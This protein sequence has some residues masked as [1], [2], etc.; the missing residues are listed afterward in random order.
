MLKRFLMLCGL[1]LCSLGLPVQAADN[2]HGQSFKDWLGQCE[3]APD[4]KE[5]CYILQRLQRN[6]TNNTLMIT[7][8]GY[9]LETNEALVV[10]HLPAVLDVNEMLLFKTDD[11]DAISINYRCDDQQCR[12]G[13]LLDKR[14]LGEFKRGRQALI[15]FTNADDGERVLLPV[16]LMGFTAGFKSLQ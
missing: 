14:M 3:V 8:I 5:F 4:G 9:H 1:G 7:Q 11:N 16:S 6:G 10:F 15:G 13:F 12:G 2:I